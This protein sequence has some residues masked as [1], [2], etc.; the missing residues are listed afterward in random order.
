MR[1][2]RSRGCRRVRGGVGGVGGGH[3]RIRVDE[4]DA[5]DDSGITNAVEF[6][7]ARSGA[8]VLVCSNNDQMTRFYDLAAPCDV[9][10]DTS[11]RGR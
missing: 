11:T 5:Q 9:W 1:Q 4:S 8:E 2:G 3:R 7:A 10:D 6:F